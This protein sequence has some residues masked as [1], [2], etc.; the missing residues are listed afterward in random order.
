MTNSTD[1][2]DRITQRR[3]SRKKKQKR[4]WAFKGIAAA[5]LLYLLLSI[6]FSFHSSMST[7]IALK[8]TVEEEIVADGYV[9]REQHIINAPA[10]G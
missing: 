8:G 9:F 6:V 10:S 7:A 5:V 1:S 4:I 3:A 2:I